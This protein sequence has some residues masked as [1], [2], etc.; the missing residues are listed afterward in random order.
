M[1]MFAKELTVSVVMTAALTVILCGIY[2]VAVF[3]LA[4]GLFPGKANGSIL[5]H[6]GTA[7]GS[8]LLGQP[9][10]TP[11]YFHPRPSAAGTGYDGKAS[12]GSNLG[13][14]SKDLIDKVRERVVKYREENGLAQDAPVPADAVMA[15]GSGLDPHISVENALLQAA[16]VAKARGWEVGRVN[17][18]IQ[19]HTE[20]RTLS[21]L[22]EPRLNVL[23]LNLA[24]DR[25]EKNGK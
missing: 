6:N 16:R 4:Q 7:V 21:L 20:G 18:L 19:E 11:R 12:C 22:G 17:E 15:S 9:F 25:Q 8:E 10:N 24:L 14:T 3:A 5:Y 2:P 23:L 13:P 1:K